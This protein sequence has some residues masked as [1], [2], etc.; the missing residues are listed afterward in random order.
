MLGTD[1]QKALDMWLNRRALNVTQEDI[2]KEFNISSR[3]LRRHIASEEG[4]LYMQQRQVDVAK[5]SLGDILEVLMKRAKEGKNAKF[6]QMYLQVVG[7]LGADSNVQVNLNSK[8]ED[9]SDSA[10][11]ADLEALKAELD[12]IDRYEKDFKVIQGGARQI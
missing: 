9:R 12:E 7:L 10:I 11:E 1:I 3:T 4:K 2:A 8:E 5:E 6:M